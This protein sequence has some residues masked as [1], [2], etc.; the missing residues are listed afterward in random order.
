MKKISSLFFKVVAIVT[1]F[2][3]SSVVSFANG[4]RSLIDNATSQVKD[5]ADGF[6]NFILILF[7][8]VGIV[9][10]VINGIK[11]FKGDHDSENSLFKVGIGLIIGVIVIFVIKNV[12]FQGSLV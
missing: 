12:F 9:F 10:V 4:A 2:L 1:A 6:V 11:Y 5:I 8:M 3:G 7:G